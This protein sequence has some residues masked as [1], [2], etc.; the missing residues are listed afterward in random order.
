[1]SEPVYSETQVNAYLYW[2]SC[3]DRKATTEGLRAFCEEMADQLPSPYF[4]LFDEEIPEFVKR[5]KTP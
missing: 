3:T 2:C 1:M 5:K 4:Q